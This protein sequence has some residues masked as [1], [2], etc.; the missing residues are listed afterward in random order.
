MTNISKSP[1]YIGVE[2]INEYN[3]RLKTK[4]ELKKEFK[5]K[6]AMFISN[7]KE[8]LELGDAIFVNDNK[9]ML[10]GIK[11][12][13]QLLNFI[14][15]IN[16]PTISDTD[17]YKILRKK[18]GFYDFENSLM[19]F[20]KKGIDTLNLNKKLQK[21]KIKS[22]KSSYLKDASINNKVIYICPYTY[23]N[24]FTAY[25]SEINLLKNKL[26]GYGYPDPIEILDQTDDQNADISI[27]QWKNLD[28]SVLFISA[29]GIGYND[30]NGYP[31]G[32]VLTYF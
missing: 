7:I 3:R 2:T 17:K 27:S 26:A 10:N 25:S 14:K 6:K 22:Y 13:E 32:I 11:N 4:K 23:D 9:W 16:D 29:H 18:Y 20:I 15:D 12:E 28:A 21:I 1:V 19:N 30:P 31:P 24:A 5:Q 8:S